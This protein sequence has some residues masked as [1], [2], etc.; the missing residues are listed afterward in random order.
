MT[1]HRAGHTAALRPDGQVLITGGFSGITEGTYSATLN[2][3]ELYDPESGKFTPTGPMSAARMWRS[4]TL[5]NSGKVSDRRRRVSLSA[6][7]QRG[8]VRSFNRRIHA[9]GEHDSTSRQPH[10]NIALR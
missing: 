1:A 5:L 2:T 3:A 8:V 9:N 7:C 10:C 6:V 4:A